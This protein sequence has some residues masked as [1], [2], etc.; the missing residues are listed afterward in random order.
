MKKEKEMENKREKERNWKQN[1]ILF[2]GWLKEKLRRKKK[3]NNSKLSLT[4][5]PTMTQWGSNTK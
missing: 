2:V 1:K 4:Y 3:T 5:F